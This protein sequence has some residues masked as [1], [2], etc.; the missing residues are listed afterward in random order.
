M[1]GNEP[2][3]LAY[4]IIYRNENMSN[5]SLRKGLEKRLN[6]TRETKWFN[7]D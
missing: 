2:E 3:V 4:I 1:Y 7:Y 5:V 6:L